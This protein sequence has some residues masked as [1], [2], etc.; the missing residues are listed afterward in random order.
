MASL[1]FVED[2][3]GR[4]LYAAGTAGQ[5]PSTGM[6][7]KLA[8]STAI[9]NTV[10]GNWPVRYKNPSGDSS[11][12]LLVGTDFNNDLVVAG[13]EGYDLNQ[14]ANIWVNRYNAFGT[15]LFAVPRYNSSQST[16]TISAGLDFD[17]FG[18]IYVSGHTDMEPG[19]GHQHALAKFGPAGGTSPPAFTTPAQELRLRLRVVVSE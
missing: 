12:T 7:Y 17:S 2:N 15:P 8:E 13:S 18:N 19:S 11:R 9:V 4:Y 10:G 1:A 6:L 5:Y 16:P 3:T 14:G